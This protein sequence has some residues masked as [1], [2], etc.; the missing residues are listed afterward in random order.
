MHKHE[1]MIDA[2]SYSSGT[3]LR[4]WFRGQF[5]KPSRIWQ[6]CSALGLHLVLFLLLGLSSLLALRWGCYRR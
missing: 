6:S 3:K 5:L 4:K 2:Y 1:H